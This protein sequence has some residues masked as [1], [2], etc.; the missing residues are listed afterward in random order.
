MSV[1]EKVNRFASSGVKAMMRDDEEEEGR[2]QDFHE[3]PFNKKGEEKENK[4]S[5]FM[6]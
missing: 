3:L 1:L 2:G 6:L 4:P 5:Q